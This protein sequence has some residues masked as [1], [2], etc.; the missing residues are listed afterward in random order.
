M[1]NLSIF[2]YQSKNFRW[3]NEDGSVSI[4][5]LAKKGYLSEAKVIYGAKKYNSPLLES[6]PMK[7]E[8]ENDSIQ[9][10][11]ST[12]K[13][14][15]DRR[16][17]YAFKVKLAEDN[18]EGYFFS[19]G[20]HTLNENKDPIDNFFQI[21]HIFDSEETIIP[22]IARKK[23]AVIQI[24]PDRF[25]IGDY[26]KPCMKDVNLK[27]GNT[28]NNHS[29][30][31]GDFKGIEDHLQYLKDLGITT[32]YLTPI[33]KSSS[34]HRYD[35]EDYLKIDDRLGGEKGFKKLV[36]RIHSN[37]ISIVLDG[38]FNHTSYKNNMFQD[39]MEN[40]K[41]SKYF[42]FYYC[43]GKP[44]FNKMNYL[45]FG[46][47]GYMPKLRT[48]NPKVIEFGCKVLNTITSKYNIDGWRF[49]VAD[50]VAHVFWINVHQTLRSINPSI[51]M[52]GEDWM[53][54][55]NYLEGNQ[56]DGVMNYQ[57]RK[58][59][60]ELIANEIIN[61]RTA[62]ERLIDLLARYSW[63]NDL[64]MF[65]LI[66]SHDTPRFKTLAEG[67]EDKTL[68]ATL[69]AVSYPGMFMSYYGDELGMEGGSD[70]LNRAPIDWNSLDKNKEFQNTYKSILSLKQLEEFIT[71]RIKIETCKDLLIIKRYIDEKKS[72]KVLLNTRKGY[73]DLNE[74]I[75]EVVI[76]HNYDKSKNRLSS[77]GYIVIKN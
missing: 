14:K 61:A 48:E 44:D 77:Y 72:Y 41:E 42:D 1:A 8:L 3:T 55:E 49:D 68:L 43:D 75:D 24:F 22:S 73:I 39:V 67:N 13:L 59:A 35:V 74:D 21:C 60:I 18:Q 36:D 25:A 62:R 31:G 57:F 65:N 70:P 32:I 28:P 9:V 71:G 34:N 37:G 5:L 69:L 52:I 47:A 4:R 17:T 27:V 7:I 15:D 20:L 29:F 54:S 30:F 10:F 64:S 26:S 58:I 45:T 11:E 23:G 40:G 38:V 53:A 12:L 6:E 2:H 63:N 16:F 66:S 33:F 51:L 76:E 56:F 50:E 19:D 46:S